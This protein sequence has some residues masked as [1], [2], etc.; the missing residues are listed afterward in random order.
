M[1]VDVGSQLRATREARGLT[2]EQAFKATRIK[3]VYLEA[4]EANR[5]DALP[6]LVQARGFVRS[7]ANF[8][9]LDGEALA[10]TLD[11]NRAAMTPEV[12]QPNGSRSGVGSASGAVSRAPMP[13]TPITPAPDRQVPRPRAID[14]PSLPKLSFGAKQDT[15][16]A[17]PGG[18]PTSVLIIGAIALFVIGALLVISALTNTGNKPAP[19]TEPGNVPM[20]ARPVTAAVEPT[21][22]QLVPLA[23]GPVVITLTAREHGWVRVTLDGQTAFEGVMKPAETRTYRAADEV[24]VEAGN[25]A[26]FS[27]DF[28]GRSS[29]LGERGQIVARAFTA[30][31]STE[32]PLAESGAATGASVPVLT[33]RP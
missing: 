26:A 33:A 13:P 30:S 6:G 31:G 11:S 8:L 3:P 28:L 23:A 32:V 25:A 4:L 5:I 29:Q 27:I 15:A 10:S 19:T 9:G 22:D 24:I 1:V 21:T 16:P 14:L 20:S 7:Y 17:S 12:V 2:I 18:V